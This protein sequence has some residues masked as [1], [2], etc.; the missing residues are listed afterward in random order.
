M[1]AMQAASQ[2]LPPLNLD[3][4]LVRDVI[5]K[6][7]SPDDYTERKQKEVHAKAEALA[8]KQAAIGTL[9]DR[10]RADAADLLGPPPGE[11]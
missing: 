4:E 5:D 8:T 6:G 10:V 7:L 1:S 11:R 2:R 3:P 9:A